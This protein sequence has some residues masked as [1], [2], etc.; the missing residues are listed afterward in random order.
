MRGQSSGMGDRRAVAGRRVFSPYKTTHYSELQ[1]VKDGG[2]IGAILEMCGEGERALEVGCG[3]GAMLRGLSQR[4][5]ECAGVEPSSQLLAEALAMPGVSYINKPFEELGW[6]EEFDCVLMR[7]VL[8]HLDTPADALARVKGALRV[9]GRL[10]LCEGVPPCSA[11]VER[12]TAVFRCIDDRHIF[13][14]SDL[15]SLLHLAGLGDLVLRPYF[16]EGVDLLS[17]L[18]GVAP[19]QET[20]EKMLALHRQGDEAWRRAYQVSEGPTWYRMT[21]RWAIIVAVK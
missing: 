2:L 14:E 18:R 10:V 21:W 5:R 17:W 19:D 7:N 3:T 16:M 11:A 1:W 6:Q 8:H 20:Y 4:Y 13:T 15:V 12:Y 9:G